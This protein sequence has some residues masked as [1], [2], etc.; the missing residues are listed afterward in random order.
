MGVCS[1]AA[2]LGHMLSLGSS[3]AVRIMTSASCCHLT[4]HCCRLFSLNLACW[5]P[6][7]LLSFCRRGR[8]QWHLMQSWLCHVSLQVLYHFSIEILLQALD[9][10]WESYQLYQHS[11][12]MCSEVS[13]WAS[14]RSSSRPGARY[15]CSAVGV[16]PSHCA[17]GACIS[18]E[19]CCA[20][21]WYTHSPES[22]SAT[23]LPLGLFN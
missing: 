12:V 4:N 1:P 7:K 6:W 17:P 23:L 10:G 22:E 18:W 3:A 21:G 5:P 2:P 8:E 13:V 16:W 19:H 14:C 20:A 9:H 15:V 11:C